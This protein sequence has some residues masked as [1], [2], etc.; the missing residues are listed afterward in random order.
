ME[1]Q[2]FD[3]ESSLNSIGNFVQAVV[4]GQ[5]EDKKMQLVE[6]LNH[7]LEIADPSSGARKRFK[8]LDSKVLEE[9]IKVDFERV[10]LPNEIW[11]KIM[12]YLPTNDILNNF[13]HVC[14]RFQGLIGDIKYLQA[15]IIDLNMIYNTS[16]LKL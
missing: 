12:N 13:G 14:R 10:E 6:Q 3:F 5:D 4:S 8:N 9:K 15:K 16:S 2:T 1:L 7:F 11:I